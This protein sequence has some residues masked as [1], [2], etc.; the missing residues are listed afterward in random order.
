MLL[1]N[2]NNKDYL[3]F[4]ISQPQKKCMKLKLNCLRFFLSAPFFENKFM[5]AFWNS[6]ATLSTCNVQLQIVVDPYGQ[7][8]AL[9]EFTLRLRLR[10][11]L[12][13]RFRF[14][15]WLWL[16]FWLRVW[17]WIWRRLLKLKQ[18]FILV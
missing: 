12:R 17:L 13:F 18:Y 1:C 14:R 3:N 10:R 9:V 5:E 7:C 4:P 11:W 6:A 15:S 2:C 8:N 16:S